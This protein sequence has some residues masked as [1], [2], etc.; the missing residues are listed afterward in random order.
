MTLTVTSHNQAMC[1]N[2]MAQGSDYSTGDN[3][4]MFFTETGEFVVYK[5]TVPGLMKCVGTNIYEPS[6]FSTSDWDLNPDLHLFGS[7]VY[8]GTDALDEAATEAGCHEMSTFIKISSSTIL[9]ITVLSL[10]GV[11]RK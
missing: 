10:R 7:T 11:E 5:T 8:C 3:Y 1:N 4:L 6:H 9:M 2:L